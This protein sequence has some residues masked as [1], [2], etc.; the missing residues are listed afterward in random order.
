MCEILLSS[1]DKANE[2]GFTIVPII[3]D[4][5]STNVKTVKKL[6]K[7]IGSINLDHCK[8]IPE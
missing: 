4:G 3:F 5:A 1:L 8:T 6:L 2:A 7:E